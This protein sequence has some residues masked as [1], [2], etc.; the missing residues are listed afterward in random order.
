MS[1]K[2]VVL[3]QSPSNKSILIIGYDGREDHL[4][5]IGQDFREN[6]I[7]IITKTDG[8]EVPDRTLTN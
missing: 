5:S 7:G 4:E 6:L 2:E 1:Q 3:N 8:S